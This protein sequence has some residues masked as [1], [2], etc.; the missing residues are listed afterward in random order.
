[1][2]LSEAV[3]EWKR[4]HP[5]RPKTLTPFTLKTAQQ[6]A[7]IHEKMSSFETDI[8]TGRQKIRG[9]INQINQ[10]IAERKREPELPPKPLMPGQLNPTPISEQQAIIQ[11]MKH[12]ANEAQ[13]KAT[14]IQPEDLEEYQEVL[15]HYK[16]ERKNILRIRKTNAKDA[17]GQIRLTSRGK[18][19][20][21][22]M[23]PAKRSWSMMNREQQNR[24]LAH[25]IFVTTRYLTSTQ[26]RINGYS[27]RLRLS[28]ARTRRV[29][30]LQDA[31]RQLEQQIKSK[32]KRIKWI[33]QNI[34]NPAREKIYTTDKV[35]EIENQTEGLINRA[36]ILEGVLQRLQS[37]VQ[38]PEAFLRDAERGKKKGTRRRAVAPAEEKEKPIIPTRPH[39]PLTPHARTQ[40]KTALV[41]AGERFSIHPTERPHGGTLEEKENAAQNREYLKNRPRKPQRIPEKPDR[42]LLIDILNGRLRGKNKPLP[43]LMQE[44]RATA[45]EFSQKARERKARNRPIRRTWRKARASFYLARRRPIKKT[46]RSMWKDIRK[47]L[48]ITP[49]KKEEK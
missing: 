38:Q 44:A 37:D 25:T 36:S 8:V 9:E 45:I 12:L 32:E 24:M 40:R 18:F 14:G 16:K 49:K 46:A 29:D 2:P 4:T 20:Q 1:M 35:E 26:Q 39:S 17:I 7:R 10:R 5:T 33:R 23:N 28:E 11:H 30:F 19:N 22:F 21:L 15:H 41:T 3:E 42:Q 43:D 48:G 27:R 31:L 47:L 13:R 34:D 6:M